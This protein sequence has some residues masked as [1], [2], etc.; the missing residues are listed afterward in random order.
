MN[1]PSTIYELIDRELGLPD[2]EQL[3]M[4][5]KTRTAMHRG[6]AS[7]RKLSEEYELIGLCGERQFA[8][9]VREPMDVRILQHGTRRGNFRLIFRGKPVRVDVVTAREV[10]RGLPNLAV[11]PSSN[12]HPDL[13]VLALFHDPDHVELLGWIEDEEAKTYGVGRLADHLPLN[14]IIPAKS[15]HDMPSFF[16]GLGEAVEQP[17][18]FDLTGTQSGAAARWRS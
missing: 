13:Y 3:R 18:L 12:V 9:E 14:H 4:L 15:L 1:Q 2:I 7:Q 5:A 17:A 16:A 10:A 11:S 8:R 6:K